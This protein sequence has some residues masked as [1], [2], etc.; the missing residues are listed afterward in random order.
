M[1]SEGY[2]VGLDRIPA[3]PGLE[4]R[5]GQQSQAQAP[6]RPFPAFPQGPLAGFARKLQEFNHDF[7]P[8]NP[9]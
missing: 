1:L 6:A 2:L 4:W 8:G 5:A 7:K 3:L 9:G